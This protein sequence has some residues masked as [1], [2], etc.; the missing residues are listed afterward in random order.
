MKLTGYRCVT[1][2]R[3]EGELQNIKVTKIACGHDHSMAVTGNSCRVG[4]FMS[5]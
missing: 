4:L 2:R 3:V 5:F 1:P